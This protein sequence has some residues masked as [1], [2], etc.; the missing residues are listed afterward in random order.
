MSRQAV[1]ITVVLRSP[2]LFE[3][4]D[5][6][7][8]AFDSSPLR[9]E[10]DRLVLPGDHLRGHLRHALA[11]AHGGEKADMVETLFGKASDERAADGR[12]DKPERG[13]LIIGDLVSEH[14]REASIYHRVQI[15][16]ATGAA[17]TGM[18]QLIELAAPMG[19]EVTFKG[20]IVVRPQASLPA[21]I[22]KALLDA[23]KQIPA[24]GANKSAGFGEV[25]HERC[26]IKPDP[27]RPAAVPI[28]ADKP[29]VVTVT[30]DRP[31][32]FDSVRDA[33]NIIMSRSVIPGAALKGT[34][35]AALA[36][37]GT[38]VEGDD[39]FTAIRISH[40]W[41]M[42]EGALADRAVP[43]SLCVVKVGKGPAIKAG[44]AIKPG[45]VEDL[46]RHG[47]PAFAG[48]WKDP[49]WN[50]ARKALGR[51]WSGLKRFARGRVGIGADGLADEGK[52]F[53]V[54]TVGVRDRQWRFTIDVNGAGPDLVRRVVAQ[55]QSGL[56]GMGRTG[57][58]MILHK[59]EE[60]PAIPKPDGD[61]VLL[62]ETPAVLTDPTCAE[63]A[64]EQ[65]ARYVETHL[66]GTLKQHFARRSL[67]GEYYGFRFRGYGAGR[68]QPFEVTEPGAVFEIAGS[69]RHK[70]ERALRFGLE[71]VRFTGDRLATMGWED[72]PF[73]AGNGYGEVSLCP[74]LGAVAA[75]MERLAAA[76]W[77]G[78]DD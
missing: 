40:A 38:P 76:G 74:D 50:L 47:Y 64:A 41:P 24:M 31:I 54:E 67:A 62:L 65:Y 59:V 66:G 17:A 68:Y 36:D 63:H 69:D 12:Q 44:S 25:V 35:A 33:T 48:D 56:D 19:E 42:A 26:A 75:E 6:S 61:V 3:G 46:A 1:E 78:D 37:A 13:A 73:T 5:V 72:C 57:A 11:A 77:E 34:L 55:L 32:L 30:F 2:F 53:V 22:G 60:A 71:P 51:P 16:E 39:A 70:L 10:H 29:L 9:D 18:L 27:H 43:D 58:R 14:P 7:A 23:L 49:T 15:S 28:Q 21:D 20:R 52:L 4:I 8:H 45:S